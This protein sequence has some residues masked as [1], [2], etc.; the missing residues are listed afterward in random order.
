[1]LRE[2]ATPVTR[3]RCTRARACHYRR[4]PMV[5][6]ADPNHLRSV[7]HARGDRQCEPAPAPMT[8]RAPAG[9]IAI[10]L[11][12]YPRLSE[13][14]IAQELLALEQR[15]FSLALFSL[16][17]PTDRATHP[18]HAEIR[19][20][21]DLP[22]GVPAP[23]AS[24]R[25]WRAWRKRA[26]PCGL[27]R[28]TLP[29]GGAISAAI[30]RA[31]ASRR[32]GQA[33]VLAAELPADVAHLHAHFLHTPASVTRYAAI[34]RGLPW[35]CSAHAKDIWTTSRV[36]EAREARSVRVDRHMHGVQRAIICAARRRAG[37][38]RPRLPRHRHR[39]LPGARHGVA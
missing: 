32:F 34:L 37:A 5:A 22:A 4:A 1:M 9:S 26:A 10:V 6:F 36:G 13:T 39:A 19:A 25:V 17:H 38:R 24:A 29:P 33:L 20:P 3:R 18:V 8:A 7:R 14:F 2:A 16:R 15:G 35:S 28:G 11:K 30:S 27:S 23:R 21:V 12:G 31:T